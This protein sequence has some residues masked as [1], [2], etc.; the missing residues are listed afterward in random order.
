MHIA[1][2]AIGGITGHFSEKWRSDF[3]A[4]KDAV[5]R[6]YVELHPEL[7]PTKGVY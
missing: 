3:F 2:T 4:E 6:H 5:L 7:F 1:F